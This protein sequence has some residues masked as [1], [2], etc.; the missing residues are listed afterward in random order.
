MNPF[1][2]PFITQRLY[3]LSALGKSPPGVL[4]NQGQQHINQLVV[5]RPPGL[6]VVGC[7]A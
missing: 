5:I 2:V 7:P 4:L 6:V 1:M 3:A